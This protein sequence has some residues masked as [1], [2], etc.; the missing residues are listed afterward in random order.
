MSTIRDALDNTIARAVA[1][2]PTTVYGGAARF[3]HARTSFPH[4]RGDSARARQL[5]WIPTGEQSWDGNQLTKAYFDGLSFTVTLEITYPTGKDL[6]ELALVLCEDALALAQQL[7][8]PNQYG[9]GIRSR[10]VG[11]FAVQWGDEGGDSTV[12][13][14]PITVTFTVE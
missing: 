3:T 8:D 11:N 14:L 2:T 4:G 9:A 10:S 1:T 12:L 13:A 5:S 6:H 7:V